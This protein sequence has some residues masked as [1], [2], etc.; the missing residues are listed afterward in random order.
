MIPSSTT[1][2]V[3]LVKTASMHRRAAVEHERC[4]RKETGEIDIEKTP[5]KDRIAVEAMQNYEEQPGGSGKWWPL[6]VVRS[7]GNLQGTEEISA[8]K[9]LTVVSS[10]CVQRPR[11]AFGT[12]CQI[13]SVHFFRFSPRV[14]D[15][16][17]L[18]AMLLAQ[19]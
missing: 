4:L 11:V 8:S 1:W 2:T 9:L 14:P 7:R 6:S 10:W 15:C 3:I 12:W 16:L 17:R 18:A 5:F 19:A 13:A